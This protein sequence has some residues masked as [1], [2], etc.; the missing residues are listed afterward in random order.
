MKAAIPPELKA[1][2]YEFDDI[3]SDFEK[4]SADTAKHLALIGVRLPP[5]F[6]DRYDR[7]Q[8]SSGR[9]FSRKVSETIQR[10]ICAA[11]AKAS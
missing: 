6:K 3:L 1:A 10:L 7:L 11:E 9:R 5:E 4:N 2:N 8:K